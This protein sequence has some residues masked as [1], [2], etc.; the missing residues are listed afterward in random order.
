MA[1]Y[2]AIRYLI[3]LGHRRIAYLMG[4]DAIS[5]QIE[6]LKGWERAM[7]EAN[8]P[9]DGDLVVQ[10]DPRFYGVLPGRSGSLSLVGPATQ[11]QKMPQRV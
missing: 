2:Q 10:A 8:L 1:P 11:R 6:R 5:T 3:G 4:I 7:R 9:T